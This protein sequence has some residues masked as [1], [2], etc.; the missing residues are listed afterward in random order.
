MTQ[1]DCI[2]YVEAPEPL[3]SHSLLPGTW[4]WIAVFAAVLLFEIWAVVTD[5]YTMSEAVW[6]W[7]KWGKWVL[8]AG[9]A[10]LLYHLFLER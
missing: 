7:P 9:F 4:M 8:G 3:P 5:N 1:P 6:S 10:V 2:E